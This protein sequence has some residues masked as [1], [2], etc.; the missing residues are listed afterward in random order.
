[1]PLD[2]GVET[3]VLDLVI[4][5]AFEKVAQNGIYYITSSPKGRSLRFLEFDSGSSTELASLPSIENSI[6]SGLAVS[7]DRKTILY[8]QID[9]AGSDLMI[10]EGFRY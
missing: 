7:P 8:S 10:V 1:M 2:G 5:K 3:Q 4:Q 9:Q 6:A